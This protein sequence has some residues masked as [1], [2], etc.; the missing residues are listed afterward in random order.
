LS[1]HPGLTKYPNVFSPIALGPVEIPNRIYFSPHGIALEA[2]SP[3][4][5]SAEPAINR[6]YYFAERAAGGTGLIIHSTQIAP[7]FPQFP[8]GESIAHADHVPSYRRVSEAVHGH[9]AKIMAEIWYVNW[10][11]KRWEKLGPL[12]PA[13]GPSATQNVYMP[14]VRRAMTKYEIG[15]MIDLYRTSSEHVREA[16]Y[17]G[18]QL[19]ISHG[20]IVEYFLTP[21][22]NKRTDEYGGS[23]ENRA[24]FMMEALEACRAGMTDDMSLGIR[25]NA[26]EL[27]PGGMDEEDTREAIRYLVK[28]QLIDFVDLDVSMEPE[29]VQLMTTGMF[30]PVMHNA[31]RVGRVREAAEPL[32]V[33]ATPGRVTSIADAERLIAN[34]VTDMVGVVRGLIAEPELVNKARDGREEERRIC[35][36]VNACVSQLSPGWGCAINPAAGREQRFSDRLTKPAS[37]SMRVVV[38]GGGPAGL[39]AARVAAMRGHTVSLF[40]SNKRLGGGVALWGDLPGRSVMKSLVNFL[41]RRMSDLNVDVHTETTATP[42]SVL[43]LSPDVVILASGSHY[44]RDGLSGFS[45]APIEGWD[46]AFVVGPEQVI[47]GEVSPKGRVLV[48]DD[49]GMHTATGVAEMLAIGGAQVDLITRHVMLAPNLEMAIPY[50]ARR[51]AE[52]GVSVRTLHFLRSIGD[53]SATI[54]NIGTQQEETIEGL[55]NVVLA[56][57]REPV[58]HLYEELLGK[59]D[60]V[61]LIGDALAP[62][63]LKEATYE[64]NRFARVIGEPNMPARIEDELFRPDTNLIL[65]ASSAPAGAALEGAE[66]PGAATAVTA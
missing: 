15:K 62:R 38:I 50:V 28:S 25:I 49:E 63:L 51:V 37:K 34:G 17:D 45:I 12:A 23:F 11:P 32:P 8:L 55:E 40:E 6:M 54:F 24:R 60:Y 42:E 4:F 52:A 59:V 16:G 57:S 61:Y 39:E 22:H 14:W 3:A 65:P 47:R 58:D 5:D 26:D 19:H 64:G 36:A 41:T 10:L 53:H 44:R 30:D 7:G 31:E 56:T 48:L 18:I 27:I 43:E 66:L 21:Y 2:A 9:G 13:L 46:Q 29:Q 1:E 20:S 35:V 33:I